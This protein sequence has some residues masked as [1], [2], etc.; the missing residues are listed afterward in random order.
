[1]KSNKRGQLQ[2]LRLDTSQRI[3][4]QKIVK[5]SAS[6]KH[7]WDIDHIV[8]ALS[9]SVPRYW[10]LRWGMSS[11]RLAAWPL[12]ARRQGMA[13]PKT[14][15]KNTKLR[16]GQGQPMLKCDMLWHSVVTCWIHASWALIAS[17]CTELNSLL[18]SMNS[19]P[20]LCQVFIPYRNSKL[21]RVLQAGHGCFN[22]WLTR[23]EVERGRFAPAR[24]ICHGAEINVIL[25]GIP[26][27][28]RFDDYD[29][30]LDE[31]FQKQKRQQHNSS[32]LFSYLP[33]DVQA[34]P[35]QFLQEPSH[36]S[37]LNS[38]EFT[39]S[40]SESKAALSP[41]KTNAD[42]SL[43]TLN[44]AKPETS[45]EMVASWYSRGADCTF[46]MFCN[47]IL[48]ILAFLVILR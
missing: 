15:R 29:G 39:W 10:G 3:S 31:G 8:K 37:H 9:R 7:C 40:H 32:W 26:G 30:G 46:A 17:P 21:T 42:E 48:M 33:I 24:V 20:W 34:G 16:Q 5:R 18:K 19:I 4:A 2:A 6:P 35:I 47:Q 23:A 41:S 38:L 43:S 13:R 14:R 12:G 36:R 28:E 22:G 25:W 11:M 1:M 44:Y 45:D 27:W